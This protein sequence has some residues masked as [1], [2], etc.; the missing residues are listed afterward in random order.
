MKCIVTGHTSGI[1]KSIYNHFLN[2]GYEVIGMSRSNGYNIIDDFKKIVDESKGCDIFVNCACQDDAQLKLLNELHLYVKNIIVLGSVS[3][4][5]AKLN[6]EYLN[7]AELEKR[8]RELSANSTNDIANILLLKL[9]FCENATLPI[10][11]D[12]KYITSFSEIN[13]VIDLWI[14]IPKI[15]FVEFV[16]KETE[17]IK[18]FAEKFYQ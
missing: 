15:F 18:T 10:K 16:L 14:Q 2:K 1:G 11:V 8:C 4:N 5:F 17:E 9:S 12:P 6:Q 3:A 7:K 13:K